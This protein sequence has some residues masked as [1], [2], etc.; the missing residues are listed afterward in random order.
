MQELQEVVVKGNLPNTRLKG[1]AMITRIQGTPLSDAGT[2]GEMLVKVPGMTGT[3]ETPEVLGKGS[4]LIYINGRLMRD[5]SELKRLRSEE[6]RDVEVINNPGAQYDATVRA[7][8][9][10]RTVRQQ[11]DGLS[12]DLTLSDEHDL[13]YDFDRPQ[14]KVGANY[15]KNGVDVF[16]SVY[17]YHQDYRQYSTIEDITTTDKV[18]RQYGPYTMTWKHDPDLYVWCELAVVGQSLAGCA[19]RSDAPDE[20]QESGNLRRGR[21][22]E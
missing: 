8:V 13:R 19:C 12:L 17:Y 22:R 11:G 4:P 5:N 14:A 18:F 6:I 21:V 9:R 1:N 7:V 16:S 15:R 10:I 3:D 20:R 2:L